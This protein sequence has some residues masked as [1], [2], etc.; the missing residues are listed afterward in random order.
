[1]ADYEGRQLGE[2]K[3]K[4]GLGFYV[5]TRSHNQ[6]E[7]SSTDWGG[8]RGGAKRAAHVLCVQK[9]HTR[10][11]VKTVLLHLHFFVTP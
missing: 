8:T 1:M 9:K 2:K 5:N 10:G 7:L 11:E 3:K 6:S 4:R